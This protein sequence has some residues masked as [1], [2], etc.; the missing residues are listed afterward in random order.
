METQV[1]VNG[2]VIPSADTKPYIR[3]FCT[4]E[5]INTGQTWNVDGMQALNADIAQLNKYKV[6]SPR[7][8]NIIHDKICTKGM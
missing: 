2:E 3:W 4:M 1:I 6:P 5:N 7:N 8:T